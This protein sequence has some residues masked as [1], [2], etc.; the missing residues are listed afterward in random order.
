VEAEQCFDRG[1]QETFQGAPTMKICKKASA[2][3]QEG[4]FTPMI[5]M[6]FQLIAFFM[7][8]I[9]FTEAD[10]NERIKL[11]SSELARPNEGKTEHPITMHVTREGTI[12][13][14]GDEVMTPAG[15]RPYLMKEKA[16]LELQNHA[17]DHA[18]IV[19]RGDA[20]SKTGLVQEVIAECQKL[21]FDKFALRAK[22]EAHY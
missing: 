5:D 3:I 4:D 18:T 1:L 14:G 9:N 6:V 17:P 13:I 12:I 11:P 16:L 19:L 20:D 7:V 10:Q 22:E 2:D 21:S 15:L 8:L